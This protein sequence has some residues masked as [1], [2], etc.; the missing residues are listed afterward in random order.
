[1]DTTYQSRSY[2][3]E[4][5][6][7]KV[8]RYAQAAA[9]AAAGDNP[10]MDGTLAMQH[11]GTN[12]SQLLDHYAQDKAAAAEATPE[13]TPAVTTA[14]TVATASVSAVQKPTD[15]SPSTSG[16]MGFK[17]WV[18]DT[19]SDAEDAV[20]DAAKKVDQK[21]RG[22]PSPTPAAT[23]SLSTAAVA[24]VQ[25]AHSQ[26]YHRGPHTAA[27]TST[28]AIGGKLLFSLQTL[29]DFTTLTEFR[30]WHIEV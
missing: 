30:W 2:T 8:A 24:A 4:S 6:R 13:A 3:T 12:N 16:I 21:I 9:I 29:Q 19:A 17:D 25:S 20:S 26:M 7:I 22:S 14:A 10:D 5:Q 15:Q 23:P 18:R 11:V 27:V 28:D 1:M